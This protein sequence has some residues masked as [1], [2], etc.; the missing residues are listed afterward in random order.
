[1]FFIISYVFSEWLY[2]SFSFSI[3]A[4]WNAG[5]GEFSQVVAY[6]SLF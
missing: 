4:V 3:Q 5:H 6:D 2:K 1:M